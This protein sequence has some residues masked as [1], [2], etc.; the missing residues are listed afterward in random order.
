MGV[1]GY[2][3]ERFQPGLVD[4][5]VEESWSLCLVN[6]VARN[7]E[8]F[9]ETVHCDYFSLNS[10]ALNR[11]PFTESVLIRSHAQTGQKIEK[12]SVKEGKFG[13]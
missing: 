4:E 6:L 8:I 1:R 13:R 9:A 7:A 12:R 10:H 3:P 11:C 2:S 5:D